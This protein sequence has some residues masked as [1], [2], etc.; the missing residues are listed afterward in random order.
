[1][2]RKIDSLMKTLCIKIDGRVDERFTVDVYPDNVAS[3][4]SAAAEL[5]KSVSKRYG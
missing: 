2:K 1:M 5:Q 3:Y 4:Y